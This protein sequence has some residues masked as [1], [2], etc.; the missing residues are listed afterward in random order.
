MFSL[1]L[2]IVCGTLGLLDLCKEVS[3]QGWV[4]LACISW[5]LDLLGCL[6]SSS[7]SASGSI[8]LV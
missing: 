8:K 2:D 7:L 1:G 3:M 4:S 6:E 5:L